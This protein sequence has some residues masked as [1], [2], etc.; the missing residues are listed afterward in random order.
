M[1]VDGVFAGDDVGDGAAAGLAG[2]LLGLCG[3]SHCLREVAL[4]VVL[5]RSSKVVA[6]SE[7][8]VAC[9]FQIEDCSNSTHQI[10][11]GIRTD[12]SARCVVSWR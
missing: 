5:V 11:N 12:R 4:A 8:I 2:G 9:E 7:D 6:S 1:E 3:G 10:K